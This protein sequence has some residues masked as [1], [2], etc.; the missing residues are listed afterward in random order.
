VVGSVATISFRQGS[1]PAPLQARVANVWR[2]AVWGAI[3]LGAVAGGAIAT[4]AGL[5]APF[6]AAAVLQLG[7]VAV[8]ALPLLRL[9]P[10]VEPSRTSTL[11]G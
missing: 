3:P 4:F 11:T 8:V 7:L 6:V 2:T 10:P 1:T 9:L 5:R